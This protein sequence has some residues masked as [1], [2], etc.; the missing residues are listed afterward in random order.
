LEKLEKKINIWYNHWLSQGGRLVLVK[1]VLKSI[2]VYWMSLKWIPKGILDKIRQQCFRFIW[3][4]EVRKKKMV[5][6]SWKR[7]VVPKSLGG[8]GLKNIFLLSKAIAKIKMYGSS[9]KVFGFVPKSQNPNIY[10]RNQ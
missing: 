9:S 3:F 4:G 7:I 1:V 2:L 10:N 5:L 8:W 6:A